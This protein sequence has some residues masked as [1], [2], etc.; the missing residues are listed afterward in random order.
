MALTT[1]EWNLHDGRVGSLIGLEAANHPNTTICMAYGDGMLDDQL[2]IQ[3]LQAAQSSRLR[4][5]RCCFHLHFGGWPREPQLKKLI[6]DLKPAR[7]GLI[8]PK[9][10]R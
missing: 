5:I 7:D 8:P 2:P 3:L 6:S 9:F 10:S 1:T 4:R